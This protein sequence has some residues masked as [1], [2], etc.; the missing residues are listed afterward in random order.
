MIRIEGPN[1]AYRKFLNSCHGCLLLCVSDRLYCLTLKIVPVTLVQLLIE[2]TR[3]NAKQ[4]VAQNSTHY[5]DECPLIEKIERGRCGL[6]TSLD[7]SESDAASIQ[8]SKAWIRD[9]PYTFIAVKGALFV[10]GCIKNKYK[11]RKNIKKSYPH[12]CCD[13]ETDIRELV[14]Y[15]TERSS[16]DVRTSQPSIH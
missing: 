15:I 11:T 3:R 13:D 10:M 16:C 9:R 8:V 12:C 6:P 1:S 2:T 14:L 4:N 7:W 5:V